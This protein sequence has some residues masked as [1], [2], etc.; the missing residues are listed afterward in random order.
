MSSKEEDARRLSLL[1]EK[2]ELMLSSCETSFEFHD[3]I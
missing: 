1:T 2:P 3:F